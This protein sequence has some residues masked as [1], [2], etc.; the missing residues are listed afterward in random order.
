MDW[1]CEHL[2]PFSVF[3]N[4][5]QRD[6]V[7]HF[8]FVQMV[9]WCSYCHAECISGQLVINKQSSGRQKLTSCATFHARR[10]RS[11][12]KL[13]NIKLWLFVETLNWRMVKPQVSEDSLVLL[14]V[15]DKLAFFNYYNRIIATYLILLLI[16]ILI[17]KQQLAG[18][19]RERGR[20][21][22]WKGFWL[23]K[24]NAGCP[25]T[26]TKRRT[27]KRKKVTKDFDQGATWAHLVLKMP[28]GSTKALVHVDCEECAFVWKE[29]LCKLVIS[30]SFKPENTNGPLNLTFLPSKKIQNKRDSQQLGP[31]TRIEDYLVTL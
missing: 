12:I 27:K 17:S 29:K 20:E 5:Q 25:S 11:L 23:D 8:F 28:S 18:P 15:Q 14:K 21:R 16:S 31:W 1:L 6:K 4:K 24:R 13:M 7:N 30:L 10:R 22:F 2:A 19:W 9:G 3:L 26:L